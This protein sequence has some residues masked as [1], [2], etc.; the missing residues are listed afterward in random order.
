MDSKRINMNKKRTTTS[1]IKHVA[2]SEL[3]NGSA[4]IKSISNLTGKCFEIGN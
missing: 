4:R 3:S 2:V 1:Y